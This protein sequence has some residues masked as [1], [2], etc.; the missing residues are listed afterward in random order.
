M[1][2]HAKKCV[3]RYC[4]L[5]N[6]K[7]EQLYKVSTPSLDEHHFKKEELESV[8]ELK[9]VCSHIVTKCLFLARTGRLDLLWSAN[10]LEDSKSTSG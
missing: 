3:E 9:K 2:E 5:A 6:K 7:T 8:G 4:E 1:E 10:K